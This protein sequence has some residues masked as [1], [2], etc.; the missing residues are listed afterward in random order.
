M[1]VCMNV[2]LMCFKDRKSTHFGHFELSHDGLEVLQADSD[3]LVAGYLRVV[4]V[5]G[6]IFDSIP[7]A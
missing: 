3:N 7:S 5:R 6:P 1:L 2:L 4:K